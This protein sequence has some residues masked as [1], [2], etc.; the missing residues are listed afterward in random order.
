MIQ[1]NS[2]KM[3]C[4]S[5]TNLKTVHVTTVMQAT[6]LIK[7]DYVGVGMYRKWKIIEFPKEC[8]I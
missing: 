7:I 6:N 5:P 1:T 3:R 4:S 8:Y 2:G